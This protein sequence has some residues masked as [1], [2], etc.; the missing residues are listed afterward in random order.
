MKKSIFITGFS[1]YKILLKSIK[2]LYYCN[3][4]ADFNKL[5]I[6]QKNNLIKDQNI[7]N[8]IKKIDEK[9]KIIKTNYSKEYTKFSKTNNNIYLGFKTCFENWKS[10]Y[11]IH[12]EDD[13]LPAYDFL[14]FN[15]ELMK[16][17]SKDKNFFSINGFSK[18]FKKNKY[19]HYS[20]FIYG[21]GKGWSMPK[22]NWPKVKKM[23]KK[24][25]G[26]KISEFFDCA[27]EN[28]IKSKFYVI[29]PYR[30]R[31]FEQPSNGLNTKYKDKNNFFNK[32]WKKSFLS[33]N[34]YQIKNYIFEKE[35]EYNWRYDCQN[36][37]FNN[38]LKRFF[39]KN[40]QKIKKIAQLN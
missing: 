39:I 35:L 26:P 33:K 19:Y 20:K 17:Y 14:K 10:E 18:E 28:E 7:I 37:T 1:R 25:S 31:T 5:V 3:S 32:S 16:L 9:I 12:L 6:L 11:V 29:M 8:K 15:D 24:I 2:K 36:Y 13:I 30:S 38:R 22:Q 40:I 27:F 23:F 21:I 4:Y 34:S